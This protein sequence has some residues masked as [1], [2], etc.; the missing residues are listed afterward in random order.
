MGAPLDEP[1]RV[2]NE[3]P[4]R[5]VLTREYYVGV[6]EVTQRQYHQIAGGSTP[7]ALGRRHP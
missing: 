6:Y 1:A 4:H 7:A 3:A 2:A 5:V